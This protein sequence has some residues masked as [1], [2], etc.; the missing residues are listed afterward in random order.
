MVHDGMMWT[1]RSLC[2]WSKSWRSARTGSYSLTPMATMDLA[3]AWRLAACTVAA[4]RAATACEE[5]T[6]L[7]WAESDHAALVA[8]TVERCPPVGSRLTTWT[9]PS[10]LVMRR[11]APVS[12]AEPASLGRTPHTL[13]CEGFASSKSARRALAWSPWCMRKAAFKKAAA[14]AAAPP[15]VGVSSESQ[16]SGSAT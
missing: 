5:S 3:T 4:R 1:R 7:S 2:S 8:T 10:E 12:A 15:Q 16:M 13:P 14:P 9:A 11:T 6:A